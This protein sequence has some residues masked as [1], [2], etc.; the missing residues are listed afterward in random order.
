MNK[1]QKLVTKLDHINIDK[2][3]VMSTDGTDCCIKIRNVQLEQVN[4]FSHLGSVITENAT[5]KENTLEKNII[6]GTVP[7]RRAR[8][9]PRMTW[10]NNIKTWTGL[11]VAETLRSVENRKQW[12][13]IIHNATNLRIKDG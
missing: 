4:T 12:R 6:Q 2:T 8:G 9:R 7:G 1:L 3:K 10:M 5:S 13:R 11:S